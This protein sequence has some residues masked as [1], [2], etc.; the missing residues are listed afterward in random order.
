MPDPVLEAQE[1]WLGRLSDGHLPP[2]SELPPPELMSLVGSADPRTFSAVGLHV[3][4][5]VRDRCGVMPEGRVLDIGCGCGRIAEYFTE[6]LAG[7]G[8]YDGFDA[9]PAMV[10][11]CRARI[12]NRFPRFRFEHADVSNTFYSQSG[13][14]AAEFVFP[15]GNDTFDAAFAASVF[16]HLLPASAARYARE[17]ARVLKP[18]GKALLTFFIINE[19]SERQL[20]NGEPLIPFPYRH[21][22]YALQDPGNPE[23]VIA[24]E[25][26]WARS[27]LTAGGL[28]IEAL[29]Y[30]GWRGLPGWTY[31][32][33]VLVSK[34]PSRTD[35]PARADGSPRIV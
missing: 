21:G 30:G 8:A 27:L 28:S 23:A 10:E 6:H 4:E 13:R 24:L 14:D 18:R 1:R 31:Q 2:D 20:A 33:A 29:S 12:T 35:A 25:E 15:Y 34:S 16:T 5:M 11:W 9:V 26:K 7:P 19:E 17:I 3:F 32:D 22:S